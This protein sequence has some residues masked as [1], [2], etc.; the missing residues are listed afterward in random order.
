MDGLTAAVSPGLLDAWGAVRAERSPPY[1]VLGY[2]VCAQSKPVGRVLGYCE[3]RERP[4]RG[5]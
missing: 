4:K 5:T 3:A 2:P 1:R